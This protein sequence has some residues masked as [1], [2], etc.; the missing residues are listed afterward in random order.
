[1]PIVLTSSPTGLGYPLIPP[2]GG[3]APVRGSNQD[4]AQEPA[5]APQEPRVD[6]ETAS[7]TATARPT[8]P[9]TESKKQDSASRDGHK[10]PRQDSNKDPQ[11]GLTPQEQ[12]V[13]HQ[14]QARD[15]EVRAHEQAHMSAGGQHAGGASYSYEMGPDGKRYAV[16]GE[17][18]ID[19][20][21]ASSPEATI[22]KARTIRKAALAPAKPSAADRQV[23]SKATAMEQKARQEL[24]A[25]KQEQAELAA[26]DQAQ[27]AGITDLSSPA[28]SRLPKAPPY[29]VRVN[30]VSKTV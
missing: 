24:Q 3:Q 25:E 22:Q 1:M 9:G 5:P 17:V 12:A 15:R 16:G 27:Q 18:P 4:P 8:E 10:E 7:P 30:P 26:R 23:A 19:A 28:P 13:V 20:S 11:M 29:E 14:L 21:E 6:S 2:D